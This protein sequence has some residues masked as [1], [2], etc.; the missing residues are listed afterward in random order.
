MCPGA[1]AVSVSLHVNALLPGLCIFLLPAGA[2]NRSHT[3]EVTQ[4]RLFQRHIE[5]RVVM[6][7]DQSVKTSLRFSV[8]LKRIS[9][10]NDS[11]YCKIETFN[12]VHIVHAL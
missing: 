6:G 3:H 9:A 4:C 2:R 8:E 7:R 5:Q 1:I 10:M 12:S 11:R